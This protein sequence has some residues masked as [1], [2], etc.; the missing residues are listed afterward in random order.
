MSAP[1]RTASLALLLVAEIGAMSLWFV[2][3]AILPELTAE[4]ALAPWRAALLSSA[5]QI[6]FVAGALTLAVHGTADRYDP[7]RVFALSAA[8][9]GAATVLFVIAPIGGWAQVGLRAATG[10]CL[11]GVYPVGMKIAVGWTVRRRGLVVGLL[12]A[13]LTLGSAAPHGLALIGGPDWR[14]TAGIAASLSLFSAALILLSR[15]GPHHA[16]APRFDPAALKLAWRIRGVRLAIAGYLCHMWELYAYWAWIAVALAAS[17]QAAGAEDPLT[18]A[19]LGAFAAIA[20][21]GLACAPA[22]ALADRFGKARI[23]GVCLAVGALSAGACAASFGGPPALTLT[24]AILWGIFVI[25]DSAQFSAL[26]A[27]AAPAERAGSLMT[28][29]TALG[30][31]LTAGTIQAA[32]MAAAAFGW[33]VTL[34]LFGLGPLLGVE[35]MRRLHALRRLG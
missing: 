1:G 14:V 4:A 34:A 15:L 32:P 30:F 20:L 18:L 10:F 22:G 29:Q 6:G 5:V 31:L 33:P 19:R 28:F 2:S 26:V 21:G 27:D 8:L 3:A 24:L 16:T 7:R 11:A 25:P 23:A 9:A 12:V 13:A 17:F 35:A